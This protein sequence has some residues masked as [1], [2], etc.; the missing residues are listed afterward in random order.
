MSNTV[1]GPID[2]NT[3]NTMRFLNADIRYMKSAANDNNDYSGALD[4]ETRLLK[5]YKAKVPVSN[6]A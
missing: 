3:W 6:A 2:Q 4:R 5:E 1:Y